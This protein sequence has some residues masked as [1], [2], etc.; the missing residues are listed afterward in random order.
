[1]TIEP[2]RGVQGVDF[3]RGGGVGSF[4]EMQAAALPSRQRGEVGQLGRPADPLDLLLGL[5]R[6]QPSEGPRYVDGLEPGETIV[7][8]GAFALK[9]ELL[10]ARFAEEE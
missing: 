2:A 3:P 5:R 9:S 6:A 1:M 10:K 4:G 8:D 7:V